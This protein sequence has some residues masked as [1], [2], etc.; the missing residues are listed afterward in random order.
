MAERASGDKHVWWL[1]K[2]HLVAT[3]LE[4]EAILGRGSQRCCQ[5]PTASSGPCARSAMRFSDMGRRN[6]IQAPPHPPQLPLDAH[7]EA[8]PCPSAGPRER[9]G[10]AAQRPPPLPGR[11]APCT[12]RGTAATGG[13]G[14]R[15][16]RPRGRSR[17]SAPGAVTPGRGRGTAAAGMGCPWPAQ[18][19]GRDGLGDSAR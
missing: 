8:S 16:G 6:R 7:S 2:S 9:V 13:P 5:L 12:R 14:A 1:A 19:G 15:R 10:A 17:Q 11:T 3:A 4:C 18:G